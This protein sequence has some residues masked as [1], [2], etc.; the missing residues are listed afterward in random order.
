MINLDDTLYFHSITFNVYNNKF[1]GSIREDAPYAGKWFIDL[2]RRFNPSRFVPR[3]GE[4][5]LPWKQEIIP[6][7][8]MPKYDPNFKK[9]FNEITDTKAI[10]IKKRIQQGEKFVVMYSGGIDSTLVVSALI[11]NLTKKELKKVCICSSVETIIENPVF[12][13][14]FI[15]GKMNV[16]DSRTHKY[17]DLIEAGYTP[18]TADEGDCIFGTLSGLVLYNNLDYYISHLSSDVRTNL[19]NLRY[20]ISDE[21]IHY[22]V[23]KDPIIKHL[24]GIHD[25]KYGRILYEKFDHN[26]KTSEVPIHSLHDFFWWS[27]FNVKYLNCSV[28]GALFYNDRVPYKDAIYKIV[29]WFNDPEYQLWS[30]V[31][32]NNGQKIGSTPSTYKLATRKYIYDVDKN[33]WY[34]NFKTKIESLWYIASSQDVSDLSRDKRPVA[35]IGLT[36]DYDMIYTNTDGAYDY[37]R[38]HLLNYKIDW[39]DE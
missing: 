24:T 36:K 20:K 7:F 39:T 31:N 22:S 11:K 30:M 5:S 16:L 28:R 27:I 4:W 14:K 6:G 29:N 21:N 8:E 23:F 25:E 15:H 10:S 3:H 17:D 13:N 2:S 19:Q 1:W 12:W 33:D 26:I 37:F 9:T 18:I 32:N 38:H 35:R 34:M